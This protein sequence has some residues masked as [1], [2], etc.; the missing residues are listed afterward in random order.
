MQPSLLNKNFDFENGKASMEG[1]QQ[2]VSL[3]PI[4]RSFMGIDKAAE[5]PL[6]EDVNSVGDDEA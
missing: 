5:L 6:D 2:M 1:L 4:A 3:Y